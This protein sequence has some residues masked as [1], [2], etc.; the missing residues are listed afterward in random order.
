MAQAPRVVAELGRPETPEETAE[1][2]A[3]FSLAYR[4]SKTTRNLIAALLVTLAVVVVIVFAVPRGVPPAP[5]AIDVATIAKQVQASEGRTVIVPDAPKNWI[6]NSATVEGDT[7]AAWTVVYVPPQGFVR[8][9]QGFEADEAWPTRV[10]GG[11]G[12]EETVTIGGVEWDRYEIRD[13]SKAGNISGALSAQA[14]PDIVLVYG[15]ADE[16]TLEQA[17]ESVSAQILQLREET[18]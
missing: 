4:S 14:G 7:T 3:A 16:K 9:A 5:E 2:K 17:A 11:A 1:R 12:A 10:L 18:P 6:V 13:P 8:I 15:S